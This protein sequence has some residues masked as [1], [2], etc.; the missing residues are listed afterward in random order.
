MDGVFF[1]LSAAG[2]MQSIDYSVRTHK[3]SRY[4]IAISSSRLTT[5][6]PPLS[7]PGGCPPGSTMPKRDR[8]EKQ[9][10]Q[11]ISVPAPPR[12]APKK[13][14]GVT[15]I[16]LTG[17]QRF[18][19]QIPEWY[20]VHARGSGTGTERKTIGLVLCYVS[21]GEALRFPRDRETWLQV[22]RN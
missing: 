15:E 20:S 2:A 10:K 4:M 6:I 8:Q 21:D 18:G 13:S 17:R 16:D 1:S 14:G 22:R 11:P 5:L 12:G 3:H 9:K 7:P 19:R